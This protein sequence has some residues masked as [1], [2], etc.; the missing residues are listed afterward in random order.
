MS[1]P[2]HKTWDLLKPHAVPRLPVLFLVLVLGSIASLGQTVIIALVE[3]LWT[4]VLFPEELEPEQ[5]AACAECGAD[6][7]ACESCGTVVLP[8][9]DGSGI[10]GSETTDA[11]VLGGPVPEDS[12]GYLSG[13]K[14]FVTGLVDGWASSLAGVVGLD[15]SDLD[16]KRAAILGVIF[17]VGV[18]L[19]VVSSASEY[20]FINLQRWVSLRMV[21]DL[22]LRLSRHLMD[23]SLRYHGGRQFGDLLSRISSDVTQTLNAVNIS[24]RDFVRYPTYAL[25]YLGMA[26]YAAPKLTV[27]LLISLPMVVAPVTFLMKRIRTGSTDSLS[28][29]GTSIHALTQMFQGIRTVKSFRAEERELE[30]F[31]DLNESYLAASMHMVRHIALSGSLTALVS[32]GGMALV[33]AL[34][35]LAMIRWDLVDN[36]PSFLIFFMAFAQVN[37][38]LKTLTRSIAQVGESVGASARL[39]ELLEERVDLVD[40]P[41][42]QVLTEFSGEV[43][44]EGVSFGYPGSDRPALD[45]VSLT[46]EPGETLAVVGPSGAGKSTLIDIVCRFI[47]PTSGVVLVDGQDLR[48]VTLESWTSKYALVGQVPFL[49]HDTI[50]AN[51]GYGLEGAT[52]Q[53]IEAAAAAADIDAFIESLPEGYETDVDDSG[54]RLSGGQRQRITIARAILKGAPVLILDEATSNLDSESEAAVQQSLNQLVAGK[55]VLIVAHRLSTIRNAHRIAVLEEGRLVELGTH[56]ELLAL[57]GTYHRLFELQQLAESAP[58]APERAGV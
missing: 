55:T 25:C 51:I 9:L 7:L 11:G 45:D 23:L 1:R 17:I 43:R 36:A 24:L 34:V 31:R 38:K 20:W 46:I 42:A 15:Y 47:D 29:L 48:E 5:A 14:L 40:R 30:R 54:T 57:G 10:G 49:F 3:P 26:A 12:D 16:H 22:R 44:L 13:A 28:S 19:A 52:R 33:V 39:Q 35:G 41:D 21:V 32:T 50:E 27:A 58:P 2:L 18:L 56:E 4:G 37:S 6:S 8:P 53:Q